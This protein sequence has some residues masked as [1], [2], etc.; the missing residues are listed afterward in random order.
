MHRKP[1]FTLVELL[2]VI[3]IIAVLVGLLL[4][5][6][7]SA[8]SSARSA[9][10]KNN[11]RQIGIA[12]HQFCNL[13]DGEFP[14]LDHAGSG[15]VYAEDSPSWIFTLAP[16]LES[17]DEIRVCPSD[18]FAGDR[19]RHRLTGYVIN[20]YLAGK[21]QGRVRNINKLVSTSQTIAVF[22]IAD[23]ST[24]HNDVRNQYDHAHASGWFTPSAI[25]FGLVES[26]VHRD[27][28]TTRHNTTSHFLY[29]DGHVDALSDQQ[30]QEWIEQ[31][32]NFAKPQ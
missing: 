27:I 16:H 5:A 14:Q 32:F 29:V 9:S 13:H 7:Q 20:D 6:V 17:V 12:I 31:P 25:S 2:V 11:L 24:S 3:A 22:E 8:R 30:V 21:V 28:S 26:L 23:P 4:P 15:G 19:L 18:L 1:G 10:C